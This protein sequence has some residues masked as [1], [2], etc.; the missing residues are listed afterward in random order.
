HHLLHSLENAVKHLGE[1]KRSGNSRRDVMNGF[2]MQARS[3]QARVI[4][5]SHEECITNALGWL[6]FAMWPPLRF[7]R[8][9]RQWF[10]THMPVGAPAC[11]EKP[12]VGYIAEPGTLTARTDLL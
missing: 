12:L 1:H 2:D 10:N 6:S 3:R 8:S 5:Y 7:G 9:I 11:L 4:L